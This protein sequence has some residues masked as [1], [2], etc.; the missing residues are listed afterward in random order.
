MPGDELDAE[1]T[2]AS[3]KWPAKALAVRQHVV[4]FSP[5]QTHAEGMTRGIQEAQQ[6]LLV[7]SPVLGTF[8]RS[9]GHFGRIIY[10]RCPSRKT[11]FAPLF[12]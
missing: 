11:T 12:A 8:V 5:A 4:Q 9:L 6:L 10:P 2:D 3:D 7:V 1:E